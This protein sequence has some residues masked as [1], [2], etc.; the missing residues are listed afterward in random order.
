MK[1]KQI[2]EEVKGY[3]TLYPGPWRANCV[4]LGPVPPWTSI[5]SSSK[6]QLYY[7]RAILALVSFIPAEKAWKANLVTFVS[8]KWVE[9]GIGGKVWA[10][11][12]ILLGLM[13]KSISLESSVWTVERDPNISLSLCQSGQYL[14]TAVKLHLFKKYVLGMEGN[15]C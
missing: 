13:F 2:Q 1:S 9:V 3:E 15:L 11:E 6:V 10:T 5:F 12:N 14:V 4:F 7:L 8:L